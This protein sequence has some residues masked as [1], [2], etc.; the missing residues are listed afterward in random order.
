MLIIITST[1]DEL[2][3]AINIDKLNNLKLTK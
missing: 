2:S 1:G 3:S